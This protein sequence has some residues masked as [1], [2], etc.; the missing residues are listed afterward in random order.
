MAKATNSTQANKTLLNARVRRSD[1]TLTYINKINANGYSTD[2]KGPQIPVKRIV[3]AGKM[4]KEIDA[5]YAKDECIYAQGITVKLNKRQQRE[6]REGNLD[7]ELYSPDFG[8]LVYFDPV[9]GRAT[10]A[11]KVSVKEKKV[12]KSKKA[13]SGK[14]EE[15]IERDAQHDMLRD[16]V[17][18][19]AGNTKSIWIDQLDMELK[20]A[21]PQ[22][23]QILTK[24]TGLYATDIKKGAAHIVSKLG[25]KK[26]R[27][28]VKAAQTEWFNANAIKQMPAPVKKLMRDREL[29]LNKAQMTDVLIALGVD[30]DFYS[31][32]LESQ[33]PR[34]R[35]V[36]GEDEAPVQSE[37]KRR[38]PVCVYANKKLQKTLIRKLKGVLSPPKNNKLPKDAVKVRVAL[39]KHLGLT[40]PK[41]IRTGLKLTDKKNRDLTLIALDAIAIVLALPDGQPVT[42]LYE[43]ISEHPDLFVRDGIRLSGQNELDVSA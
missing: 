14:E 35:I 29:V 5:P 40:D 8:P 24:A 26:A 21:P 12:A 17:P 16:D 23:I 11:K 6:L 32:A 3:L 39:T 20:S 25:L 13:R 31:Q 10:D 28:A 43:V 15:V 37:G 9:T 30:T 19:L 22:L 38:K 7:K 42:Y 1:G 27:L 4:L 33:L 18:A 41:D 36:V 34:L 2:A